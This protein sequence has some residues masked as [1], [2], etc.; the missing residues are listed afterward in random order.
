MATNQTSDTS[1]S[2]NGSTLLD[3]VV[4]RVATVVENVGLAGSLQLRV[5]HT[6]TILVCNNCLATE[7]DIT[8]VVAI[9]PSSIC[10]TIVAEVRWEAVCLNVC[11]DGDA[12]YRRFDVEC[13]HPHRCG[14][15]VCQRHRLC[16]QGA[17]AA[18][19]RYRRFLGT[20]A[21]V[22]LPV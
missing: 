2:L 6:A 1:L 8:V 5:E 12:D 13:V 9:L 11:V 20:G 7:D 19:D 3:D 14:H 17:V 18:A 22:P 16:V 21:I 4:T 15:L 10:S